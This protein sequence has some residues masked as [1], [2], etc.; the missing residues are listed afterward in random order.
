[1]EGTYALETF[2]HNLR[3]LMVEKDINTTKLAKALQ[4]CR[5]SIYNWRC[6]RAD[7]TLRRIF[8]IAEILGIPITELLKEK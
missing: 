6:G 8:E 1:M 7:P 2:P 4:V 3:E 5:M